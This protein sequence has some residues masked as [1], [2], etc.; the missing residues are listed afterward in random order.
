MKDSDRR[1]Q[2]FVSSTFDGLEEERKQAVQAITERGHIPIA[3]ENFSASDEKDIKVIERVIAQCQVY[4]LILGHRYGSMPEGAEISYTELEYDLAKQ[5]DLLILPFILKPYEVRKRRKL[6]DKNDDK[7]KT[8]IPNGEKLEAFL[9]KIGG[10]PQVWGPR[11]D[12]IKYKVSNALNDNLDKCRK[13]G[14]VRV[15]E[16]KLTNVVSVSENEFIFDIVEQLKN[17][18]ILYDRCLAYPE[19]KQALANLFNEQYLSTIK[20]R[21]LS[22]FFESGSTVTYVAKELAEALREEVKIDKKGSPNI[23]IATNNVLAYLTLWL[24][25]KVPCTTFPWSPPLEETYGAFY[26]GIQWL[27]EKKPDYDLPALDKA[28][29][30]EIQKLREAPFSLE[31][32]QPM[33]LLGAASGLQLSDEPILKFN[34][35]L[36]EASRAELTEKLNKCRGPHVGSYRNKVFKRYMYATKLPIIISITGDKIDCEIDV[37]KCHF[38]L[39]SEFTWEDFCKNHPVAFC[40]GCTQQKKKVYAEQFR[41]LGFDIWYG[42]DAL[43]VTALIARNS[44]FIEKFENA[45]LPHQASAAMV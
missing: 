45:D 41:N 43:P 17:F 26:G 27:P 1:F 16:E 18:K 36:D 13:P 22:L 3:L 34:S 37:G 19:K 12:S 5:N 24:K 42:P 21:K 25:G 32:R 4:I 2:I 30:A 7:D 44:E 39:D 10:Y 38:I 9:K 35:E 31:W 29:K 33:L 28:A 20:D 6:L 23:H 14:F 11:E 15:A 8:E 40:I